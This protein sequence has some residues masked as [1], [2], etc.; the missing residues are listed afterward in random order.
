MG[1]TLSEL[2]AQ[3]MISRRPDSDDK[4]RTLIELTDEGRG[5]LA[6]DR[7][8]RAGWIAE[9]I[10]RDFSAEEQ[11]VLVRATRLLSRLAEL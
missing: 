5:A 4:R 1:Q 10:E 6:E 7:K 2:E 11:E 9:A 8:H 3:G